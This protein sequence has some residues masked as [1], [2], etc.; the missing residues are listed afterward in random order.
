MAE[1]DFAGARFGAATDQ[2]GSGGGMVRRPEGPVIHNAWRL[3]ARNIVEL[4][5]FERL[6]KRWFW[7]NTHDGFGKQRF[8]G[9]GRSRKQ[10]VV[11]TR[12]CNFDS[13]FGSGLAVYMTEV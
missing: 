1:R 12:G 2:R 4:R 6:L 8:A 5:Y 13:A 3:P 9:S 11:P 7:Q 10:N